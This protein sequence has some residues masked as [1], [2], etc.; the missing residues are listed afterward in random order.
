MLM[1]DRLQK[2]WG[3]SP[4]RLLLILITFALGGSATGFVGRKIMDLTGIENPWAY[5]PVYIIV[6]TLVWPLMV[7]LVSI[8][9]GQFIFFRKY[10][11]KLF[12]KISGRSRSNPI[13]RIAIFASGTGSNAQKIID[14][15]RD[16][17]Y[18]K[19]SLIACN[20][21]Q[22]GV[23]SIASKENIPTI[24]IEREQFFRGDAH[25]GALQK[26]G[27]DY[28]I[29]A[30]FLW[31]IPSKLIDHYPNR[32]INI[33]PALLPKYGGKGLYGHY[34][35]EAMLAAAEKESGITIH[36]VDEHYDHGDHILQEKVTID[37]HD[38]PDT[39]AKK[40]QQL[41]HRYFPAAIETV[42]QTQ[43]RR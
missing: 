16:H 3:V 19:V 21:P 43:N 27:I 15:F 13:T 20:K 2:K 29:L 36:Y 35:H 5:I 34:V 23:L 28:I 17:P 30:G 39:L 12:R 1:L 9:F 14:H 4:T 42:I 24:I 11:A 38:T 7:L 8:P 32:I 10:I 22:A 31:K 40:V 25:I 41:E 6:V 26:N 33:H 37:P 18:I